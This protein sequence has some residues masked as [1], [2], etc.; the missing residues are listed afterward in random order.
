MLSYGER[1]WYSTG[2]PVRCLIGLALIQSHDRLGSTKPLS[3]DNPVELRLGLP[4][5]PLKDELQ[6]PL[7][8]KLYETERVSLGQAVKLAGFSKRPF[9]EILGKHQVPIFNYSHDEVREETCS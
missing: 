7:A 1:Y 9:I 2:T 3:C 6:T 8:V 5:N 4:S